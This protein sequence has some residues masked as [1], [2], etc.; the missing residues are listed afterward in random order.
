[1]RV[2]L[3]L[4]KQVLN[5]NLLSTGLVKAE[6]KAKA[7]RAKKLEGNTNTEELKK[8]PPGAGAKKE[9][10]VHLPAGEAGRG[11]AQAAALCAA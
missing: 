3:R 7:H 2:G 6:D 9:T 10:A 1:M 8:K 5:E 11:K 4:L